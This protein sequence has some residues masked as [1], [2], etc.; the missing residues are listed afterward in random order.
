[1]KLV[2][3]TGCNSIRWMYTV[4]EMFNSSIMNNAFI[5]SKSFLNDNYV[6][7]ISLSTTSRW[8]Y[9][10]RSDKQSQHVSSFLWKAS[11]CAES[12]F[13]NFSTWTGFGWQPSS[14]VCK[15]SA[16]SLS[17]SW[18]QLEATSDKKKAI[19]KRYIKMG[20]D[21]AHALLFTKWVNFF[22]VSE[23]F[24]TPREESIL[25]ERKSARY[26]GLI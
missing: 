18:R 16:T 6:P 1:M 10:I 20:R 2:W 3:E 4:Q 17:L 22:V 5:S 26:S 24:W 21:K 11:I 19:L 7:L 23:R 14:K 13:A 25:E 12:D 15:F 8:K 9:W